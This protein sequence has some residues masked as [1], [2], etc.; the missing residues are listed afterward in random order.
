MVNLTVMDTLLRSHLLISF[1]QVGGRATELPSLRSSGDALQPLWEPRHTQMGFP[2]C[3]LS[4]R[5]STEPAGNPKCSRPALCAGRWL[6]MQ[7]SISSHQKVMSVSADPSHIL[8]R[9]CAPGL[10]LPFSVRAGKKSSVFS[11]TACIFLSPLALATRAVK[12]H[13]R[14]LSNQ[15]TP[16]LPD[17]D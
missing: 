7:T 11:T 1:P 10:P 3:L 4:R 17:R 8:A 9:A 5:R 2:V 6:C 13:N 14:L 16:L 15:D 12:G